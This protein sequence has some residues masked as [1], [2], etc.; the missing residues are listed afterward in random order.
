MSVC[1]TG[2]R[3]ITVS[4]GGETVP[5]QRFIS[6]TRAVEDVLTTFTLCDTVGEFGKLQQQTSAALAVAIN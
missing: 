1:R 4:Q 2:D 6:V 5:R 3:S